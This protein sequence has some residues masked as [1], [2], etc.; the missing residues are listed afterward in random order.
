L[1]HYE[2]IVAALYRYN[3]IQTHYDLSG[4]FLLGRQQQAAHFYVEQILHLL[5]EY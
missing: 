5:D 3:I 2:P 1:L 4:L